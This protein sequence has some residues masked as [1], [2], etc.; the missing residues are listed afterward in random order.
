MQETWKFGK[1]VS[2]L[3]GEIEL[4]R[5]ILSAQDMVR[6]AVI[7]KEW[8][9]FDEKTAEVNRLGEDFAVLEEERIQLFSALNSLFRGNGGGEDKSFYDLILR[10]PAEESREL[11]RLYRELKMETLK[12][13]ALNESL[14]AYIH[15]AKAMAAAYLEAVCPARGGKLYTRKG[16][17]VSQ[18]LKS[19]VLNN[20][21]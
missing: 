15:E 2:V 8:V 21:F 18:D 11:S 20:H 14:L 16:R 13:R 3:T 1:C 4:L 17:M 10:L 9:D 19:M 5:K 6:H 12:M 7:N